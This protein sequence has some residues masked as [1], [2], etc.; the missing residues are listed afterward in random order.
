MIHRLVVAVADEMMMQAQQCEGSV[1]RR[2]LMLHVVAMSSQSM[3]EIEE[4]HCCCCCCQSLM[5]DAYVPSYYYYFFLF[6]YL[7]QLYF[8]YSMM[9]I[10]VL[11]VLCV[12]LECVVVVAISVY[13]KTYLL[14]IYIMSRSNNVYHPQL[15]RE[16][17]CTSKASY[18]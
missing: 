14:Q 11:G 9:L 17:Y 7:L 8:I 5:I 4:E 12:E 6:I 1:T 16:F 2:M 15:F 10:F 18:P 3:I 13:H